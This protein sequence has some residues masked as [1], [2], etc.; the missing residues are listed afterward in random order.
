MKKPVE[1]ASGHAPVDSELDGCIVGA[2]G[3]GCPAHIEER[4]AHFAFADSIE[5]FHRSRE[6]LDLLRRLV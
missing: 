5:T 4:V 6:S 2:H 1:P 3:A